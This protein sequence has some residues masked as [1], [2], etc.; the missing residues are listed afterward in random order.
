MLER[1]QE[2]GLGASATV[3]ARSNS[4]GGSAPAGGAW[5]PAAR[6]AVV[7]ILGFLC[8]ADIWIFTA[9]KIASL[10]HVEVCLI[11]DKPNQL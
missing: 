3:Q 1:K 4:S 6:I 9:A 10:P 5:N 11:A 8:G 2:P 7:L